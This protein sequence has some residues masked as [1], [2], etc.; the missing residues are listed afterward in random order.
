[1]RIGTKMFERAH[2]DTSHSRRR[3]C[4]DDFTTGLSGYCHPNGHIVISIQLLPAACNCSLQSCQLA[5]TI[6]RN[7]C[8]RRV[9]ECRCASAI[10]KQHRQTR[11]HTTAP[12]PPS[13][14]DIVMQGDQGDRGGAF[15]RG[16]THL[17]HLA[18]WMRYRSIC[19]HATLV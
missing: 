13:L 5:K 18:P 19:C 14:F 4:T 8:N 6:G 16:R 3:T 15:D 9:I 10:T 2:G 7:C 12:P 17:Q 11:I 1:M